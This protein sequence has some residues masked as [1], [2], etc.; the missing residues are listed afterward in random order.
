MLPKEETINLHPIGKQGLT[1]HIA[2]GGRWLSSI[3]SAI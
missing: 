3:R 2:A 1:A